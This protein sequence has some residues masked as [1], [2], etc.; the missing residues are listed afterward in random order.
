MHLVF[1]HQ[2]AAEEHVILCERAPDSHQIKRTSK[3]I[4]NE[5]RNDYITV[6]EIHIISA[7]ADKSETAVANRQIKFSHRLV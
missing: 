1:D 4:K 6:N 3:I 2:V 7:R 5:L